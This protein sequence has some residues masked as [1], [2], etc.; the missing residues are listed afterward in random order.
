MRLTRALSLAALVAAA[1]AAALAFLDDY[2][3]AYSDGARDVC[4]QMTEGKGRMKSGLC[5]VLLEDTWTSP[6]LEIRQPDDRPQ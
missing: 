1:G 5:Q 2:D 3:S 6:R 4:R